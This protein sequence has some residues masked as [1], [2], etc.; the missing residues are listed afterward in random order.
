MTG[1][2]LAKVNPLCPGYLAAAMDQFVSYIEGQDPDDVQY[3]IDSFRYSIIII[4]NIIC[5]DLSV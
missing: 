3:I 2:G 4:K 5:R 1:V